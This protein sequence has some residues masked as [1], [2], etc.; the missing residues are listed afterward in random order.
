MFTGA[1]TVKSVC[2]AIFMCQETNDVPCILEVSEGKIIIE[3]SINFLITDMNFKWKEGYITFNLS[4]PN[5]AKMFEIITRK[6]KLGLMSIEQS[7]G[8]TFS[9]Q[10]S[11]GIKTSLLVQNSSNIK[12]NTKQCIGNLELKNASKGTLT[13][14]KGYLELLK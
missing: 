7:T 12:I 9:S 13:T 6:I 1:L 8:I 4:E 10:D 14:E 5:P 11:D 2:N 3:K